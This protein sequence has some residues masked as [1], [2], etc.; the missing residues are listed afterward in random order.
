MEN[1]STPH[2]LELFESHPDQLDALDSAAKSFVKSLDLLLKEARRNSEAK[3]L[4]H[5]HGPDVAQSLYRLLRLLTDEH[6]YEA[7]QKL[8]EVMTILDPHWLNKINN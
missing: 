1:V 3:C 6:Q 2:Q 5:L 7:A 4:K 8:E